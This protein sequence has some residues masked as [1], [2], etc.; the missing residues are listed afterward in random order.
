MVRKRHGR[1][2]RA[3]E[4]A[5][6][7]KVRRPRRA[8]QT[9]NNLQARKRARDVSRDAGPSKIAR[10]HPQPGDYGMVYVVGGKFKGNYGYYDDDQDDRRCIV[11]PPEGMRGRDAEGKPR[12]NDYELIRRD[13]LVSVNRLMATVLPEAA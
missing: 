13:Y 5:R 11:Y 10:F 4:G 1:G 3:A 12:L 9:S 7:E 8:P 2:G 6:L